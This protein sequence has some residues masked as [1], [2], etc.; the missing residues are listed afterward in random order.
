MRGNFAKTLAAALLLAAGGCAS[1]SDQ[2]QAVTPAVPAAFNP[3]VYDSEYDNLFETGRFTLV[4]MLGTYTVTAPRERKERISFFLANIDRTTEAFHSPNGYSMSPISI[5]LLKMGESIKPWVRESLIHALRRPAT[6]RKARFLACVTGRLNDERA[7]DIL[8][9]CAL[10]HPSHEVRANACWALARCGPERAIPALIPLLYK[11]GSLHDPEGNQLAAAEA[12][13]T[14][15]G[16]SY[17]KPVTR[18]GEVAPTSE[19]EDIRKWRNWARQYVPATRVVLS[20]D[21]Q[22][23]INSRRSDDTDDRSRS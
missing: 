12:L 6:Y 16:K 11:H 4:S 13:S 22:D 21:V 7:F 10:S 19:W 15:T 1:I 20:D 18:E 9:V 23:A 8:A 5:A 3:F 17:P 2:P 14:I